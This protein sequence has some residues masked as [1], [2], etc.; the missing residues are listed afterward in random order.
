MLSFCCM[1][2]KTPHAPNSPKFSKTWQIKLAKISPSLTAQLFCLYFFSGSQ[3]CR[4]VYDNIIGKM[5]VPLEWRASE[6]NLHDLRF[7][8]VIFFLNKN[9]FPKT[10]TL[11]KPLYFWGGYHVYMISR[12]YSRIVLPIVFSSSSGFC[13]WR[14]RVWILGAAL[15][16]LNTCMSSWKSK[17]TP[18]CHPSQEIG[19]IN[20]WWWVKILI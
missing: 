15:A 13:R 4:L 5:V 3:V 11:I 14:C 20:G 16:C 10:K 9:G 12:L 6:A 19:H 1:R 18:L 7:K 2:K 8:D 17:G